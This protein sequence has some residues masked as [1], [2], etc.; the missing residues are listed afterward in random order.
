ME[1]TG[2]E[3]GAVVS[4]LAGPP[5]TTTLGASVELEIGGPK[6]VAN[7]GVSRFMWMPSSCLFMVC[8][9]ALIA[10]FVLAF[11]APL[12]GQSAREAALGDLLIVPGERI[13]GLRLAGS[14]SDIISILGDST[15]QRSQPSIYEYTTYYGWKLSG[16][17]VVADDA[18]G[19]IL[20]I[21]VL[22]DS[23]YG[24]ATVAT[25]E[26]VGIG[27]TKAQLTAA[28]GEPTWEF[29]DG[30]GESIY[31]DRLGIRFFMATTGHETGRAVAVRVVW[32]HV[33]VGDGLI[34]PGE[35]ISSV[36]LRMTPDEIVRTLGGGNTK[37]QKFGIADYTW[38]H[39]GLRVLVIGQRVQAIRVISSR[40]LEGAG[41]KYA[42]A[43]G[44]AIGS[45]DAH[46]LQVWGEPFR[47]RKE[48]HTF[49]GRAHTFELWSYPSKGIALGFD[50]RSRVIWIDVARR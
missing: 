11:P 21:E 5:F 17:T 3:A 47:R 6:I 8:A 34:V 14:L 25:R 44:V 37:Y 31:F 50:A 39:R 29:R 40:N 27:A 12:W 16:V 46:V 24:W 15:G 42:T 30:T 4:L 43:D 19:Q 23:S 35:R 33:M 26:R 45:S 13:G 49:Q 41:V 22:A 20:R 28:L 32:P 7:G 38:P 36:T 9:S 1:R 10:L 2:H 48:E 18:T